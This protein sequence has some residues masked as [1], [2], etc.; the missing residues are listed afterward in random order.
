MEECI[1]EKES[2]ESSNLHNMPY[3][4]N[5]L[6]VSPSVKNILNGVR[7]MWI[8]LWKVNDSSKF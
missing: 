8:S 4:N 3:S 2:R 7:K 5:K 6:F 1:I